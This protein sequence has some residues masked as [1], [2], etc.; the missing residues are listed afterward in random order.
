M[1]LGA[2]LGCHQI[3]ERSFFIKGYQFPI[4]ARCT[5]VYIGQTLAIVMLFFV[6][7]E[8]WI[9]LLLLIP[10]AID[11]GLQFLN[12]LMS[13]NIR[14]LLT[15]ILGGFGLTYIYYHAITMFM[16]LLI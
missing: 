14:R 5:G 11:W 15:G 12:I 10:M 3:A 7:I 4:C 2:W 6:K 1:G 8:W 9:N 16:Q 13:N